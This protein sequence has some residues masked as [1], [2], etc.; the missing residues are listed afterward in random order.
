MTNLNIVNKKLDEFKQLLASDGVQP[1]DIETMNKQVKLGYQ[2]SVLKIHKQNQESRRFSNKLYGNAYIEDIKPKDGQQD[3]YNACLNLRKTIAEKGISNMIITGSIGS[4]KTMFLSGV[5]NSLNKI[6][7]ESKVISLSEMLLEIKSNI[8]NSLADYRDDI[9][10]Y[11]NYKFLAIDEIGASCLTEKDREIINMVINRRYENKLSTAIVS[12]C[13]L[14][15][16]KSILG[17]RVI[18]RLRSGDSK[19]FELNIKSLRFLN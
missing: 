13:L 2:E 8:S 3:Y 16:I 5:A 17:E 15:Q 4:G 10:R 14:S 7:F 19:Y 6:N 18:D 1:I 11:G 9:A 12:N